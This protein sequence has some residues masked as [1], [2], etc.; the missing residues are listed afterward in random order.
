MKT[1]QLVAFHDDPKIKAKYLKRLAAHRKAGSF[2]TNCWWDSH[3]K[4]GCAV[5][6]T[7]HG[8][9]IALYEEELG[10]P[11]SVAWL[12]AVVHGQKLGE[13]ID[14][15]A[16]EVLGAIKPGHDLSLVVAHF[17]YWLLTSPS[18]PRQKCSSEDI[19]VLDEVTALYVRIINEEEISKIAWERA[20]NL[21]TDALG[22]ARRLEEDV[23]PA[24]FAYYAWAAA[25]D[26]KAIWE[27]VRYAGRMFEEDEQKAF[28]MRMA[29]R[30]IEILAATERR[31][32]APV[33][34]MKRPVVELKVD[35]WSERV[36]R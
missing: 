17:A 35:G 9:D 11:S 16:E 13:R 10:I 24:M 30:F 33:L 25:N 18:G 22:E 5:G 15:F 14:T 19:P 6:C 1:K 4:I 3:R 12:E 7:I 36:V 34:L 21:L 26:V 31:R 20:R 29:D 8:T 23:K 27:M 32:V 2:V 28:W